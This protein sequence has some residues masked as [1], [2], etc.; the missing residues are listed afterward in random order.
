MAGILAI[1]S[2]QDEEVNVQ[3]DE[4]SLVDKV[5]V[6]QIT[7]DKQIIPMNATTRSTDVSELALKFNSEDDYQATMSKIAQM[8]DKEKISFIESYGF[9]SLQKL[10]VIADAE[11][12]E[13]GSTASSETDFRN[14]YAIYVKKYSKYLVTNEYDPK[15]LS[16]YVPDG[17]KPSTYLINK[18]QNVVIGNEIKKISILNTMSSSDKSLYTTLTSSGDKTTEQNF[19]HKE[20]GKKTIYSVELLQNTLLEVHVGFQKKMWYGWKRDN[21]R[22]AYYHIE[23]SPF[24]YNYWLGVVGTSIQYQIN[25]PCPD[26]Y[27]FKTPGTINYKTGYITGG[28]KVLTGKLYVWND[29]NV[30]TDS[31]MY[32]RVVINRT[33]VKRKMLKCDKKNAYIGEF[34]LDYIW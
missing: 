30:G 12:E 11:L 25:V 26:I 20:H 13:I 14:K 29:Y 7:N 2:C 17:D 34:K 33:C 21:A 28:S 15:D 27:Y 5:Q 18:N 19:K 1:A 32:N 23:A 3:T 16:L 22:D 10:A 9:T 31:V 24:T 4:P 6:V 8:D